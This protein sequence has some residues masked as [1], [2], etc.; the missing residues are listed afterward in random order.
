MTQNT[1]LFFSLIDCFVL[2]HVFDSLSAKVGKR[3]KQQRAGINVQ[4]RSEPKR[5]WHNLIQSGPPC[6]NLSLRPQS[7]G[8]QGQMPVLRLHTAPLQRKLTKC[9]VRSGKRSIGRMLEALVSNQFDLLWSRTGILMSP[10]HIPT[11]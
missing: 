6:Q 8:H 11:L 9:L 1:Y 3:K 4:F 10:G 2:V 7:Q 5:Y